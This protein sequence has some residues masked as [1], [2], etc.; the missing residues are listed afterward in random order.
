MSAVKTYEELKKIVC[1]TSDE[2]EWFKKQN[3]DSLAFLIPGEFSDKLN[4][5]EIRRQFVPS[6][7]EMDESSLTNDPQ[8]EK[9]YTVCSK[10]VHRYTNRVAFTV[11]DKCFGYCRHCFRRRF[12]SHDKEATQK[13]IDDVC[14]YISAHKEVEEILVT[15]GDPLTLSNNVL[16]AL[17]T[18]LRKANE[19]LIIRLCTRGLSL[20]PQRFDSELLN[21]LKEFNENAP[22]FLI[23]QFNSQYEFSSK[24]EQKAK[25]ITSFGIAIFNQSVLLKGVNDSK[26]EICALSRILLLNRIKPYYMFQT[27]DVAGTEHLRISNKKAYE[28]ECEVRKCLSGLE[29]PVFVKDLP[30]GGGK[31]PLHEVAELE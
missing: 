22:L 7:R 8:N 13:E 23:S 15:G 28:L 9:N 3:E 18:S 12:T 11:T 30:N 26:E 16:K 21:I 20:C 2:E 29:M 24:T 14:T 10:L 27:D 6:V 19:N 5:P 17:F 31:V 4:I 1:L 25:E